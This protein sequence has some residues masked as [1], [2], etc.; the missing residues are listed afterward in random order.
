[1][2]TVIAPAFREEKRDHLRS[3]WSLRPHAA[4]LM[5][6][7]LQKESIFSSFIEV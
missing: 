5:E 7:L 3:V 4:D 2:S 1:M 6:A